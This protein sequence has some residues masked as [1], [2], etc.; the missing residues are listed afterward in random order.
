M[1]NKYRSIDG[2]SAPRPRRVQSQAVQVRVQKRAEQITRN[3]GGLVPSTAPKPVKKVAEPTDFLA[4]VKTLDFDIDEDELLDKRPVE[5]DL[6]KEKKK[7]TK[8]K[9]RVKKFVIFVV[10]LLI[11]GGCAAAYLWANGLIGKITDGNA[12]IFSLITAKD[13]ELKTG[14]NGRTNVLVFGTSGYNMEGDEGNGTHDGA[15]L[16]DS[17]MVLS[18]DQETEDLAM[19]NLPRDLY[20]GTCTSTGKINE[21]Y[22]CA[23]PRGNDEEAG[24]K[25]LEKVVGNILGI[26]FQYYVHLNWG[27]LVTAVDAVGGITVTLDED[28]NDSWTGAYVKAGEPTALNGGQALALARARHGTTGGDFTR[29]ASQQKILIALQEKVVSQGLGLTD[30]LNLLNDLGDNLRMDF[31]S[32]EIKTLVN[33]SKKLSLEGIRQVP[34]TNVDGKYYVTTAM[35]N[36][37][38]YVVPAAGQKN[39]TEIQKYVAKMFSSD[40]ATREDAKI[41][42]LNGTGMSGVAAKEQKALDGLGFNVTQVGDAPEGVYTDKYYLYDMTN[43]YAGTRSSLE[44]RYGTT[45]IAAENLPEG[46][47]GSGYDFIV[48]IGQV[49]E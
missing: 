19:L 31:N 13:V 16:T 49:E 21:V 9:S 30:A 28:V 18:F 24:A 25:A 36:G 6:K 38:S 40:P 17:I 27:S 8:K 7:K 14:E 4:P 1:V 44:N 43:T 26:D 42:V 23:N 12:N 29:G 32:D 33:L 46:I 34:L 41:M 3:G 2:I 39:Y 15:Q 10:V 35:I 11:L 47:A 5:K 37:V 45:V 20:V 22:W 48:I